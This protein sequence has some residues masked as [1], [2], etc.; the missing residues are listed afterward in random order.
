MK[1]ISYQEL[2]NCQ[3]YA[4]H[5]VNFYKH[6]NNGEVPKN[7]SEAELAIREFNSDFRSFKAMFG[8]SIRGYISHIVDCIGLI[9][10]A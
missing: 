7:A 1:N 5:V 3:L 9:F 8:Y 6:C 2:A 4:E 10:E